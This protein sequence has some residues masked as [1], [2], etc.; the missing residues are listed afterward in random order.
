MSRVTDYLIEQ[1]ARDPSVLSPEEREAVEERIAESP[2]AQAAASFWEAFFSSSEAL[3]STVSARV[4]RFVD[5]LFARPARL[6]LTPLAE[7]VAEAAVLHARTA[8]PPG[9][10]F[11]SIATLA[12]EGHHLVVR[13]LHDAE[14][15]G[16]AY[17]LYVL[18]DDPSLT[19]H[20]LVHLP[21]LGRTVQTDANGRALFGLA[22]APAAEALTEARIHRLLGTLPAGA[23]QRAATHVLSAGATV[24]LAPTEAQLM[25]RV[26]TEGKAVAPDRVVV[27]R[28]DPPR[29]V[30]LTDDRARLPRAAT[31]QPLYFYG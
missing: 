27:G 17:R 31:E 29:V 20:A 12:H 30:F 18:A 14:A 22:A 19:T 3:Q 8:T 5:T 2:E 4:Q 6:T 23:G 13:L 11:R 1:W 25:V 28:D 9:G 16:A 7:G 10:R 24:H 15:Q 26:H 21:A